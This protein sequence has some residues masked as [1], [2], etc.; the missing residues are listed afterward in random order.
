MQQST[1][2]QREN[3]KI[4]GGTI[5]INHKVFIDLMQLKHRIDNISAKQNRRMISII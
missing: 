1:H 2:S 3:L 5:K 4:Y